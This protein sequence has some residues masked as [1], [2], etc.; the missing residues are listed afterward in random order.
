MNCIQR[1]FDRIPEWKLILIIAVFAV[2]TA[3][4]CLSGR[5]LLSGD[6]TRVAGIIRELQFSP[7]PFFLPRLNGVPFLEY[8]PLYYWGGAFF[9]SVLGV[10]YGTI[11]AMSAL[12]FSLSILL[13]FALARKL[14]LDKATAFFSA[15][16]LNFAFAYFSTG[17]TCMVDITLGFFV[18]LAIFGFYSGMTA[19]NWKTALFYYIVYAAGAGCAVMTKGLLGLVL[20]GVILFFTLLFWDIAE[21]KLHWKL[22]LI[23]G[24][25]SL[26]AL[27]PVACWAYKLYRWL[28][29]EDFYDV[30]YTNNLGR[31]SGSQGDH[32]APFYY[33]LQRLPELFQPWLL[34]IPFGLWK[35]WRDF[36]R[37]HDR[38]ALFLL[39]AFSAPL[40]LLSIA[41]AKRN[42]YLIPVYPAAM[43]LAAS[44]LMF[45]L[46]L[47]CRKVPEEKLLRIGRLTASLLIVLTAAA[48]VVLIFL[49]PVF[50][51]WAV[52]PL[53]FAAAGLFM[54]FRRKLPWG[55]LLL[56]L[57]LAVLFPYAETVLPNQF[58]RNDNLESLFRR[59]GELEN[60]NQKVY[61]FE[62]MER[63]LGA[64]AYYRG[65]LMPVRKRKDYD[66]RSREIWVIRKRDKKKNAPYGD[67][68]YI[69]QMPEGKEL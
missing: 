65:H 55:S 5:I 41:S 53:L 37:E 9:I 47:L 12:S 15:V 17:R 69:V 67:H 20:P 7:R 4:Y 13:V 26:A 36:R 14:K 19:A 63:L 61:L 1:F 6:E 42:V 48:A 34:L 21:R 38:G 29:W 40:L 33:Y 68:H 57:T 30:M 56:L 8:P 32:K 64:A 66:G 35:T 58:A 27:I 46:D 52:L 18:L 3:F 60:Q 16:M 45:L 25:A 49:Y 51:L 23:L 28:G 44:G 31:F 54:I 2:L 24:F 22:W 10:S 39:C 11:K 50:L 59:I 62:P 43:L